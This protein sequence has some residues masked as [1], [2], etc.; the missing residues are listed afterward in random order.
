[1]G[2]WLV[3]VFL[4]DVPVFG[5]VQYATL[6]LKAM[7]DLLSLKLDKLEVGDNDG[8]SYAGHPLAVRANAWKEVEHIGYRLF[9]AETR[10]DIP[11]PV[12]D[13]LERYFLELDLLTD[14]EKSMRLALDKV[15]LSNTN[16]NVIHTFDGS[17][18][19]KVNM[20]P[21]KKYQVTWSKKGM[22]ILTVLFDMDYQLLSGCNAIESEKNLLR[23]LQRYR[24]RG[25]VEPVPQTPRFD[26]DGA[27]WQVD[28]GTYILNEIRHTLYY[29]RNGAGEWSLVC[30]AGH[31]VWSAFNLML[32]QDMDHECNLEMTVD[33]YGY[34]EKHVVIPLKEWIRFCDGQG[35]KSYLGIKTHRDETITGT[36][37]IVNEKMGYNHMLT[38]ELDKEVIARRRGTIRSRLYAYIPLHNV[39]DDYFRFY[40]KIPA[41]D[42]LK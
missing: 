34:Q 32:S 40:T 36:V 14:I 31:P 3:L 11:Y 28:D 22:D 12:Y 29:T 39:S 24:E 38:V 20:L 5:Q 26:T 42:T 41:V 21:L 16:L 35:C 8:Y 23:D 2:C 10:H 30:D 15:Q 37:F 9:S 27:F 1:M 18:E 7:A 17:E 13:F 19:L 4:L 6:R 25:D 33:L